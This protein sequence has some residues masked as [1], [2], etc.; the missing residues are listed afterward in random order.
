MLKCWNILIKLA[1]LV[2]SLKPLSKV[3]FP[4]F[5]PSLQPNINRHNLWRNTAVPRGR[6]AWPGLEVWGQRYGREPPGLGPLQRGAVGTG[7]V[8][9]LL[10]WGS[11]TSRACHDTEWHRLVDLLHLSAHKATPCPHC[12]HQAT[13]CALWPTVILCKKKKDHHSHANSARITSSVQEKWGQASLLWK[14]ASAETLSKKKKRL[15]KAGETRPLVLLP[16][17]MLNCSP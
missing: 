8:C 5:G 1:F 16:T 12:G 15:E 11:S 10:G 14:R 2:P 6:P 13:G 9:L 17:I 7:R 4:F 3:C